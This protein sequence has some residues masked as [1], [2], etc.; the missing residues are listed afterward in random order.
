MVFD[1][2]NAH[3]AGLIYRETSTAWNVS[4]TIR[5]YA[6]GRIDNLVQ[7]PDEKLTTFE[8][9][10]PT[11]IPAENRRTTPIAIESPAE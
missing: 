5:L 1:E 10:R 2:Q 7:V 11:P 6:T 4:A 8:V 9:A 3:A